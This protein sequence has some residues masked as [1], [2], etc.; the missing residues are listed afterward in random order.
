M[1]CVAMVE[2]FV[3]FVMDDMLYRCETSGAMSD[4]ITRGVKDTWHGKWCGVSIFA[5]VLE[6]RGEWAHKWG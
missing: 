6:G 2:C 3:W 4:K 1:Q 5:R